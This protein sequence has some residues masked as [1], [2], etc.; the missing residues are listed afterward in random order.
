MKY[1]LFFTAAYCS[2]HS[3]FS[4]ALV[5]TLL[6]CVPSSYATKQTVDRLLAEDGF[7]KGYGFYMAKNYQQA[8][9]AYSIAIEHNPKYAAAYCG[10][11]LAY[12]DNGDFKQAVED[13]GKAIKM[14]SK[15]TEAYYCRG[16]F[17]DS[18]GDNTRSIRDYKMAARLGHKE[19]QI[20]LEAR[21][22]RW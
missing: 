2:R 20:W 13:C 8:I 17:Y 1:Y 4:V 18:L 14:A 19:A 11:G 22:L 15:F 7:N 21:E 5:A 9:E 3:F 16:K 6:L 10:R 12:G